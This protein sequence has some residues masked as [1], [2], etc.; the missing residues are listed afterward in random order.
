ELK[1]WIGIN[2]YMASLGERN[3]RRCWDSVSG[4]YQ[5][6]EHMSLLRFQQIRRYFHIFGPSDYDDLDETHPVELRPPWFYKFE[7]V[8]EIL[9]PLFRKYLHPGT[10]AAIDEC[11]AQCTGRT[12][13]KTHFERKPIS[14]G[15]KIIALAFVGYIWDF[16]WWS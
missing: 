1:I 9:R 7:P 5:I 3:V 4:L 14:D 13:H 2:L 15:Y 6:T 8:A 10:F 16:L 12:K 11:V